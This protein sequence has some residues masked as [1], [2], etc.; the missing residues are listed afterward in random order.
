MTPLLELDFTRFPVLVVDDEQDNL[1]AFRFVFR[2]SFRLTY[3]QGGEQAL[4]L[5]D[6]LDPAVIVTDQRMPGLRGI[7]VLQRATQK[8]PDAVGVLLTAY[9]DLPVLLE[10]INSGAVYRYVQKPWDSKELAVVLRQSIERFYTLRENRRLREQLARYAGYL[11]AEQRNPMDFGELSTESLP[12]RRAVTEIEKLSGEASAVLIAGEPGTEKE[13]FARALHVSS[14]RESKP[15]VVVSC[16]AFSGD[17]LERELFGWQKGAFEGALVD[18][19]GR[20]ELAHEG[21]LVLSEAGEL[22]SALVVRLERLLQ[23]GILRRVGATTDSRVDV[24]LLLTTSRAAHFLAHS[25]LATA[26]GASRIEVPPLRMRLDDLPGMCTRLLVR[27]AVRHGRSSRGFAPEAIAKLM[28]YAWP[29]NLAELMTVVERAVLVCDGETVGVSH[30]ALPE[31]TGLSLGDA[32]PGAAIATGLPAQLDDLERRELCS[33]L[34]KCG[35]NKAEVAR[36]LGIQ[37]TT[38]YYRLKRLGIEV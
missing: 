28:T 8:R 38:L 7:E 14:P 18:R 13:L 21:T 35:G 1:D 23:E 26:I 17:A 20:L 27:A 6:T 31:P 32:S 12:M 19:P 16:P 37:R 24:R 4:A 30:L 2:K 3:A 22:S 5:I 25:P 9:T 33:A 10:A 36:L 29:G 34:E 11:E 15:F